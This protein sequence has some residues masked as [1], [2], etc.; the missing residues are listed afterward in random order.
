MHRMKPALGLLALS[1]CVAS[2][3]CDATKRANGV[4]SVQPGG[5]ACRNAV[6]GGRYALCGKLTSTG[7][8]PQTSAPRRLI[9]T[10]DAVQPTRTG[11][12]SIQEGT[13]HAQ[14]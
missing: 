14:R 1:L 5:V 11:R 2:A 3:S 9:G 4:S 7:L 12:Y 13:F 10:L 6:Q 8:T